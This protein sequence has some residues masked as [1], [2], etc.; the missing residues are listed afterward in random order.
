LTIFLFFLFIAVLLSGIIFALFNRKDKPTF[1]G[2]I[3]LTIIAGGIIFFFINMNL[4]G[5]HKDEI[6]KIIK[7]HKGQVINISK[8]NSYNSPFKNDIGK[9]N[10]IYKIIYS[11]DNTNFTAWYRATN[12][13][14]DIHTIP[15]GGYGEKWIFEDQ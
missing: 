10:I 13:V 6:R 9:S 15:S 5:L 2:I 4:T 12:Y 7:E 14:N 8:V 3:V 1:V 11:K